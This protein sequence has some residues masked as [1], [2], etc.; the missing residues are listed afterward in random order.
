MRWRGISTETQPDSY[1]PLAVQLQRIRENTEKYVAPET[2]AVHDRAIADLRAQQ[3]AECTLKQG[4][5]APSFALPDQNGRELRSS[6]MLTRGRLVVVFFRGRWCPYC[7]TQLES[8]QFVHPQ[9]AETGATLVAISPQKVHHNFLTADQHKLRFPILSDRANAVAKQ[10]G[11]AYTVPPE[12]A[13][14]YRRVFVNLATLNGDASDSLPLPATFIIGQDS[15]I[16]WAS[17][18]EDFRVRPE[19]AEILDRLHG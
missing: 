15:T 11:I 13:D 5:R 16:E 19:P 7:V 12:Q 14:L 2:L 1:L 8:L 9:I 17:V 10:F 18:N 4:S 3:I 6:D